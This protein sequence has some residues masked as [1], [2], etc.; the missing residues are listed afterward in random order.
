MTH[1]LK[2]IALAAAALLATGAAQ[3]QSAGSILVRVGATQITPHVKSG[4]LTAPS[5]PGTQ[6]DIK[7]AS[8]LSGGVTY[9]VTDNIAVDVPLALPFT[10]DIVGAGAISGVGKIG[11]VRALPITVLGQYRFLEAKSAFRPFL[12][13]GLT[14]A[15]FYKEKSEA[16]LTAMTGGS[17]ASPTTLKVD[18]KL[19]ATIGIGGSF[20]VNERCF[21]EGAFTKTFLKTTTTLS[22][23]QT[24][25]AKLDPTSVSLA[26]GYRF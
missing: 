14:Y 9:M 11:E 19:A 21:I 6:A 1:H 4:D 24:L 17:P 15:K 2:C 18:S 23:G 10:H 25:D 22:T 26:V 7:S 16:S 13:A 20:M 8:Q 5:L 3:A 12:E